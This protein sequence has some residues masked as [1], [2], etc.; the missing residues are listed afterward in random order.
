MKWTK[1]QRRQLSL[2]TL[3][4]IAL[5]AFP[6]FKDFLEHTEYFL[7]KE[8]KSIIKEAKE[9]ITDDLSKDE[10]SYLWEDYG[11]E[12]GQFKDTFPQI[13]RYSLFIMLMSMT[14]NSI[15]TLCHGAR[16]TFELEENFNQRRGVVINRGIEYLNKNLCIDT[17]GYTD[18]IGLADSLRK[19]RNCIVHSE[20]RIAWRT[21]EEEADLRKFIE[22]TSMLEINHYGQIVILEGFVENSMN[23]AKLLIQ[24][25]L[26]SISEIIRA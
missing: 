1:K 12:L 22:S 20:G 10:A 16:Q 19:V 26:E 4:S 7:K 9:R 21:E 3:E 13:L 8:K 11:A 2:R 6:D 14:E 15:V 25:L 18:L 24:R 17:S 23:S 5:S